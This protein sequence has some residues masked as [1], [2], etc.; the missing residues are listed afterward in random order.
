[1][2]CTEEQRNTCNVEKMNCKGCYYNRSIQL[3]CKYYSYDDFIEKCKKN[4]E[5]ICKNNICK[6]Y[7]KN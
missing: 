6:T 1:M 5:L 3:D 7:E 2:K 4:N